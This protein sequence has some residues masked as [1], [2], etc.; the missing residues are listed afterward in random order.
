MKRPSEGQLHA[1]VAE[2]LRFMRRVAG[3]RLRDLGD[4][5]HISGQQVQKYETA[6][7]GMRLS[8]FVRWAWACGCDP[9]AA[10]RRI[11]DDANVGVR[12]RA[13]GDL[14]EA[15]VVAGTLQD[16]ARRHWLAIG[17]LLAQQERLAWRRMEA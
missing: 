14:L 13:D 8:M 4:D 12:F 10:V 9:L 1:R 7:S 15:Q 3:A 5:L 16:D 11:L 2:E 17:K 6:I